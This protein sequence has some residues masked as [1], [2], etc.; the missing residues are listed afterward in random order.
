MSQSNDSK[1]GKLVHDT[2]VSLAEAEKLDYATTKKVLKSIEGLASILDGL[3]LC[4]STEGDLLSQW[5][6]YAENGTG[7]AIGFSK[8]YLEWLEFPGVFPRTV[9]LPL[10]EVLYDPEQHKEVVFPVFQKIVDLV[11]NGAFNLLEIEGL[12]DT[13]TQEERRAEGIAIRE[14]TG[15]AI[16]ASVKLANDVYRLKNIAFK[17]EKE[18]RLLATTF[19]YG[20]S[21][22]EFRNVGAQI[23]RYVPVKLTELD[24]KPIVE[25][26][27]GPKQ[28]TPPSVIADFLR[29]KGFDK[30]KVHQSSATYR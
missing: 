8:E 4:L 16:G 11:R 6:G 7:V 18:W 22:Y 2:F 17:E 27:L 25:V 26:I 15:Q 1:E 13:R 14:I 28:I 20:F 23:M 24:R 10:V 5:R 30:A 12:A 29:A 21:P 9:D 19:N 3:G